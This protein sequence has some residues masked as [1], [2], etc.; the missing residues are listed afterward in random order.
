MIKYIYSFTAL[1]SLLLSFQSINAQSDVFNLGDIPTYTG[2][3]A[4]MNDGNGG[5]QP[6]SPGIN[7][8]I[9]FCPGTGE[10]QSNLYFIGFGL[11]SGDFISI[12][13]GETTA[14]PLIGTYTGTVLQYGTISSSNPSGCLT[15]QFTSNDDSEIGDFAVQMSCGIPCDYP[16]AAMAA[17]EDTMRICLNEEFTID[18]S[19]STWTSGVDLDNWSWSLGDGTFDVVSWPVLTHSFSTPGG[20]R[21]KL[22][23]QDAN[24]CT[25]LNL[26]EIVVL[27]STPFD[28]DLSASA[29]VYCVGD[30]VIVGS[31]QAIGVDPEDIQNDI[32]NGSS[33]TWTEGGTTSFDNGVYIPDNQGC[34]TTE[35]T[36]N[37]FGNNV[38]DNV[39]DFDYIIINMEHSFIGD[40]SVDV[41]CPN[42]QV[43]N[44]FPSDAAIFGVFLGEPVDVEDPQQP[45]VGY[46]YTFSPDA[47]GGT[48]NQNTN[49]TIPEGDYQPEGAWAG[50]VGCPL[51]GT[52]TLQ[53]CDI[54]GADDGFV[55]EFGVQFA[56]EFYSDV[57]SFTPQVGDG[58][59]SS[60]WS[61]LGQ[62]YEVGPNC[63]WASYIAVQAG[64]Q[65]FTY[66]V[67]NDFGCEFTE[68]VTVQIVA[69]PIITADDVLFCTNGQV[70]QTNV[71]NLNPDVN[72]SY[73]WSPSS[74]LQNS[75]VSDPVM[76]NLNQ[77]TDYTVVVSVLNLPSCTG[78]TDVTVTVPI[79]LVPGG[80]PNAVCD[81]LVDIEIFATDQNNPDVTYDWELTTSGDPINMGAA[82]SITVSQPGQY[83]VTVTEPLCN[84]TIQESWVF[85]PTPVIDAGAD[86][87]YC[88]VLTPISGSVVNSV[89][90]VT[91]NYSWTPTAPLLNPSTSAT[92][93]DVN[94]IDTTTDF[95]LSATP[96]GFNA[97]QGTDIV[98]AIVP[99][100][101]VAPVIADLLFCEGD[102]VVVNASVGGEGYIYN[103]YTTEDFLPDS[104][105]ASNTAGSQ[106]IGYAGVFYL[107]IVEPHCAF[108]DSTLIVS[109][110]E[111]CKV[112]IPN[113]F[114]PDGD[115]FNQTFTIF[116]IEKFPGSSLKI[117]NRWGNMV[118]E[119][120]SYDNSWTGSD[121]SDGTYYYIF[122]L[123]SNT[124]VKYFEGNITIVR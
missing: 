84:N 90:G 40:I 74:G 2:C 44:I 69:P 51:N 47:T 83:I 87:F 105:I 49:S 58:C 63:D 88:D 29:P 86:F 21:I 10:T 59:D 116:G 52:W 67:T 5:L 96:V 12:Y 106:F 57:L 41:F 101:P 31:A 6:Y 46:E 76:N 111:L 53:I 8:T 121:V 24:G 102:G 62:F 35:V 3:N 118:Y 72:Y 56:G 73:N 9:T 68:D 122:E 108:S 26:P 13:D 119:N 25:S 54:V 37:Q 93:I 123:Q 117:F 1:L 43:I 100:A 42:G 36:F 55:F 19:A 16:I 81:D 17:E 64:P 71:T 107:E 110:T 98:T 78:S 39:S 48:W 45:G 77:T 124:E 28:F 104:L 97:C 23:I 70:L 109:Q 99:A 38:I 15:F 115:N 75:T 79:P 94:G 32:E 80:P 91:Y 112:V 82:N 11:G 14:S 60:S 65:V 34:L 20:Y 30:T 4:V 113:I 103:W 27:V 95:T 18:A 50:L 89:P 33:G 114:T 85:I 7:Q 66:S 22:T 92:S 61:T 120:T